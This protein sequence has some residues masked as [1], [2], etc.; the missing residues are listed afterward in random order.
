MSQSQSGLKSNNPFEVLNTDEP[1]TVRI[2][3]LLKPRI[4][5]VKRKR[6]RPAKVDNASSGDK[7]SIPSNASMGSQNNVSASPSGPVIAPSAIKPLLK[8]PFTFAAQY[9]GI[10]EVNLTEKEAD[11][12]APSLDQVM[13][14]YS[15]Q[16]NSP[17][18]PLYAFLISFSVI[19]FQ[20][21]LIYK[22]VKKQRDEIKKQNEI[23][24]NVSE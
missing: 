22:A 15:S 11:D 9:T 14:Q 18:A 1:K 19:G 2:D 5:E 16:M 8:A 3:D 23:N 13:R 4:E 10:E 17:H 6:G 7:H 12:L 21:V 20:K 24:Q